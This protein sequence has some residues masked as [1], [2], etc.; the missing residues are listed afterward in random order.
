[1]RATSRLMHCKKKARR[2]LFR[3]LAVARTLRF[4][5]SILAYQ[6]W[7]DYISGTVVFEFSTGTAV[8]SC[9]IATPNTP[10]R[11]EL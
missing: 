2:D 3:V 8:I 7:A 11:S 5:V 1:M 4:M 10:S 6:F 9:T